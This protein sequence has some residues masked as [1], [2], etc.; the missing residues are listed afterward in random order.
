MQLQKQQKAFYQ[1]NPLQTTKLYGKVIEHSKFNGNET[2][3]DAYSGVGTIGMIL[4]KSVKNVISVENN[5]QA[6]SAAIVNSKNICYN[7]KVDLIGYFKKN[8]N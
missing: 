8:K 4:S 1:V 2:I 3:I 7:G 5:K 6:V